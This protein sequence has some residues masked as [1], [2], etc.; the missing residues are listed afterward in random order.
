MPPITSSRPGARAT[1]TGTPASNRLVAR[2]AS[3]N[4]S[5][6]LETSRIA[7]I[8]DV[9]ISD[10]SALTQRPL[11]QRLDLCLNAPVGVARPGDL[12]LHVQWHVERPAVLVRHDDAALLRDE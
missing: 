1:A 11:Q 4:A 3:Q 8:S 12:G 2:S 10:Q 5:R 9:G 7:C 6:P